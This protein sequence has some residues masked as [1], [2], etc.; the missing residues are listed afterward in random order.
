[1]TQIRKC[2]NAI[3]HSNRAKE[4]FWQEFRKLFSQGILIPLAQVSKPVRQ[5]QCLSGMTRLLLDLS[6]KKPFDSGVV[7]SVLHVTK[8]PRCIILREQRKFQSKATSE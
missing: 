3:Y 7:S 5:R 4:K 2:I 1:M 6:S 8:K